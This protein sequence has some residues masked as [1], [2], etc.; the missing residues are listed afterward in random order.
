MIFHD[1]ATLKTFLRRHLGFHFYQL[2]TND[3][4]W[5]HCCFNRSSMKYEISDPDIRTLWAALAVQLRGRMPELGWFPWP[6]GREGCPNAGLSGTGNWG[7]KGRRDCTSIA[8]ATGK[9]DSSH[10]SPS[11]RVAVPPAGFAT[12]CLCRR[13]WPPVMRQTPGP[14]PSRGLELRLAGLCAKVGKTRQHKRD[15][16]QNTQKQT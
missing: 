13:R 1:S 12:R 2:S 16:R 11:P 6:A 9:R 14:A 3:V 5:D 8:V 7:P 4:K 15:T 10:P